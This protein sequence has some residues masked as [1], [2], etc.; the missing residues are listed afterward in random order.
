MIVGE[1][2]GGRERHR[3][4]PRVG[5][6]V[7][8]APPPPFLS[9]SLSLSLSTFGTICN[10]YAAFIANNYGDAIVVFDEYEGFSTKDMT[11]RRRSNGK[12]GVSISF[13]SDMKLTI[14]K[15]IFL[16]NPSNKKRFI[17][18][19]SAKLRSLGCKV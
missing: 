4:T 5:N 3:E 17:E 12:K 10:T 13:T 18:L 7:E 16:G 1:R 11:H 8:R 15:D 14:T 2:D 9:L 6:Y 19:L